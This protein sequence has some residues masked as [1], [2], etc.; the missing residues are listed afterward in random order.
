MSP[1]EYRALSVR[2]DELEALMETLGEKMDAFA[3]RSVSESRT[4]G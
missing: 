1:E 4:P 2:L 3:K